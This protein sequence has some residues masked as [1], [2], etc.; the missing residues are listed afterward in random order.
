MRTKM[1]YTQ[2]EI[3]THHKTNSVYIAFHCGQNEMNFVSRVIRD[4]RPIKGTVKQ[5]I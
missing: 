5:I 1:K 2:K 4:K 3:S